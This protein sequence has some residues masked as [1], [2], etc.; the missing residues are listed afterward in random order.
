MR[1]PGAVDR[2]GDASVPLLGTVAEKEADDPHV[3]PSGAQEGR[4]RGKGSGPYSSG[5][6]GRSIVVRFRH[7]TT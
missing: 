3:D 1:N 6:E 7:P 5:S 2:D 4:G